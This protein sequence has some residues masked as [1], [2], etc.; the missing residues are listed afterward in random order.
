[1]PIKGQ[2][3][4]T[5]GEGSKK[6]KRLKLNRLVICN[7]LTKSDEP[8]LFFDADFNRIEDDKNSPIIAIPN[9]MNASD[10]SVNTAAVLRLASWLLS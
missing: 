9:L 4:D 8:I 7:L 2:R 10:S 1:M 3:E 5:R 6:L